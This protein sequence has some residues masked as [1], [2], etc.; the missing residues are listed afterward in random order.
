M[1]ASAKF[2]ARGLPKVANRTCSFAILSAGDYDND[3]VFLTHGMPMQNTVICRS[4]GEDRALCVASYNFSQV[5]ECNLRPPVLSR[6]IKSSLK[7][8]LAVFSPSL[9]SLS[10]TLYSSRRRINLRL[11]CTSRG[12]FALLASLR[13]SPRQPRPSGHFHGVTGE[14]EETIAGSLGPRSIYSTANG[15]ASLTTEQDGLAAPRRASHCSSYVAL[16]LPSLLSPDTWR[17]LFETVRRLK[18]TF[19]LTDYRSPR[20]TV[21]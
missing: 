20:Y 14:N 15:G 12:D 18:F 6:Y 3:R 17:C 5:D 10:F 9:F 7:R 2:L 11:R 1:S 8:S 19:H 4:L 21:T 16:N 13:E